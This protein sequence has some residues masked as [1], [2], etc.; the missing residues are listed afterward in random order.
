METAL[1]LPVNLGSFPRIA[2]YHDLRALPEQLRFNLPFLPA[3]TC[4]FTVQL[5]LL[6]KKVNS[7]HSSLVS[8]GLLVI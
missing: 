6:L 8:L 3:A 2:R 5:I 4:F 7:C 1:L